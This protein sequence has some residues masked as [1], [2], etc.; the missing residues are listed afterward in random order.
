MKLT[1]DALLILDFSIYL[2]L[3]TRRIQYFRWGWLIRV[4]KLSVVSK[5]TWHIAKAV[6]QAIAYILDVTLLITL[7]II[8]YALIGREVLADAQAD[9]N[10]NADIEADFSSL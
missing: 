4:L 10:Y 7:T 8:I 1:F 9:P 3:F 6:V 2:S 5:R